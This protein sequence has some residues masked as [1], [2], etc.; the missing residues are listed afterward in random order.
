MTDFAARLRPV[1]MVLAEPVRVVAFT[2]AGSVSTVITYRAEWG[3]FAGPRLGGGR[4]TRSGGLVLTQLSRSTWKTTAPGASNRRR[5]RG[6]QTRSERGGSTDG[7]TSTPNS[8]T[9]SPERGHYV[10]SPAARERLG[11]K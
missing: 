2:S 9:W 1:S 4:H 6:P 8:S 11:V 5:R 7:W 3:K 10:L